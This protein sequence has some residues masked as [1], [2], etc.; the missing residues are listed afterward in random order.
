MPPDAN[1]PYLPAQAVTASVHPPAVQMTEFDDDAREEVA[2]RLGRYILGQLPY[3]KTT[4]FPAPIGDANTPAIVPIPGQYRATEPETVSGL[5]PLATAEAPYIRAPFVGL[6]GML[7]A[8][9]PEHLAEIETWQMDGVSH[10]ITKAI[11]IWYTYQIPDDSPGAAA[12]AMRNVGAW[13]LVGYL[14]DGH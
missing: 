4:S 5:Y 3:G 14:G 12:G 10:M 8:L 1:H 11:R 13:L 7:S 9:S 6:P 2:R